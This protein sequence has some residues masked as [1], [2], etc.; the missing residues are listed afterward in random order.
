L[1]VAA[2]QFRPPK[3]D[4]PAARAA[5]LAHIDEAAAAGARLIVCPELAT[6]GYVW[7][8]AT[9]ILPHTERAHGATFAALAAA[10][11]RHRAWVVCGFAERGDDGGLYNA[12]MVVGPDGAL[13]ATY[14]KVLLFELDETWATPGT[15]RVSVDVDDRRMAPAICMD[16]NDDRFVDFVQTHGHQVIP[17]CTNWLEQGFDVVPY[18]RF[19][20]RYLSVALIAANSWGDDEEVTFCGRSAILD[21]H[22]R[23]L[24][25]APTRG[26]AVLV[27]DLDD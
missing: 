6:T 14:R 4:V 25:V 12:A 22:G 20:L 8:S 9:H 23:R 26:D 10:A 15:A 19:R 21:R 7:R 27:A 24:A 3:G 17:F 18:W 5:L 11:A 2:I 1:R 16:L 13:V